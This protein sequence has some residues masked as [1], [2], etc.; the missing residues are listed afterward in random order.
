M[1]ELLVVVLIV[2]ILA[3]IALPAFINQRDRA[4]DS[5]AKSA[6]RTAQT[7]MEMFHTDRQ[8][9]NTD[10]TGLRGLEPA[11]TN[12][13]ALDASGTDDTF[14]VSVASRSRGATTF[15]ISK[16]AD[17]TVTHSCDAPGQG[18]CR[19]VGGLGRW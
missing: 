6:A 14:T 16:A 2:G 9:Y 1:I 3:T 18:A 7:A 11:L 12:A 17:G 10:E 8:S 15:T 4:Q 5:E 19:D 13:N